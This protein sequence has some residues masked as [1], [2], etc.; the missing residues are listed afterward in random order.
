M[1]FLS[2]KA[3]RSW[4]RHPRRPARW[5]RAGPARRARPTR[6]CV[7]RAS[8]KRRPVWSALWTR[9]MSATLEI[10]I[11]ENVVI[12]TR[13]DGWPT[14]GALVKSADSRSLE[15]PTGGRHSGS[16][17]PRR[18]RRSI[19]SSIHASSRWRRPGGRAVAATVIAL[20]MAAVVG[21]LDAG[22]GGG[23]QRARRARPTRRGSFLAASRA[24]TVTATRPSAADD[25]AAD[26]RCTTRD[27]DHAR[28]QRRRRP[29]RRRLTRPKRTSTTEAPSTG[30]APDGGRRKSLPPNPEYTVMVS[31]PR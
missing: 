18:R 16:D 8:A 17:G 22:P 31:A 24:A 29:R 30:T 23:V 26:V 13:A 11:A 7:R 1:P 28:R 9:T 5:R 3:T 4:A 21:L 20:G 15:V 27:P 10:C 14:D 6:S 12:R 2:R 25:S 19:M